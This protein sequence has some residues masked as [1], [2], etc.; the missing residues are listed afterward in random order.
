MTW[1]A[2]SP[3]YATRKEGYLPKLETQGILTVT[4]LSHLKSLAVSLQLNNGSTSN[5]WLKCEGWTTM[6]AVCGPFGRTYNNNLGTFGRTRQNSTRKPRD[7]P[8]VRC[9]PGFGPEAKQIIEESG[10]VEATR[11]S[12]TAKRGKMGMARRQ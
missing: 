9:S 12:V 6:L 8:V 10:L 2:R 4:Q 11:V 7:P 5:L 3:K 1:G